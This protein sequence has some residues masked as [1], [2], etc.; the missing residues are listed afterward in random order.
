MVIVTNYEL[1]AWGL[2]LNT[3][4]IFLYSTASR[5]ALWAIQPSIQWL[6]GALPLG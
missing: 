6:L 3:G 4:N 5:L 2:I 1:D